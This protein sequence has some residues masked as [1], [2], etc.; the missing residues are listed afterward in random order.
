[1]KIPKLIRWLP[2]AF[3]VL[4]SPSASGLSFSSNLSSISIDAQ[5]GQVVNHAFELQ[6]GAEEVATQFAARVED[7]WTSEDGKRSF[8]RPPGTVPRSCGPWVEL[9]PVESR[10]EPGGTLQV[11]VTT[12][13][14]PDAGSGGYWCVLTVDE[15][16]DPF[17]PPAGVEVRFLSSVSVGIFVYL[18]P[19][20][21]AARITGVTVADGR[22]TVTVLNEGNTP[23]RV[24]GQFEIFRPGES[25][26]LAVVPF[27]RTTL[28]LDPAP[29]RRITV[30]LP[31]S[32]VLPAGRY[33]VRAV[34][35]IG[36]D[37]F[38]AAQKELEVAPRSAISPAVTGAEA[39]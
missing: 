24:E 31:D 13:I 19:V 15:L 23:A 1:M 33:L 2:A 39:R 21:R 4:V 27:P 29:E 12:S 37:Y 28:L 20:E 3:A 34:L 11:R 8:Y 36:L 22:A 14:P 32:T 30:D 17:G 5:P 35:D 9:N 18:A 26:P 6:L 7:W 16:P 38:L 25:V 10:V